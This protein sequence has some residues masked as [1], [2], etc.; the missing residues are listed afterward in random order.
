MPIKTF[1]EKIQDL[2]SLI[3]LKYSGELICAKRLSDGQW[4]YPIPRGSMVR[5]RYRTDYEL[6]E[7]D[8]DNL[9][10]GVFAGTLGETIHP[11]FNSET[12]IYL[13]TDYLSDEDMLVKT[14]KYS[15]NND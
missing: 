8:I 5:Y 1:V 11:V 12:K 6:Y 7:N 3:L 10:I 13:S 15:E 4:F 9:F 14:N 2:D